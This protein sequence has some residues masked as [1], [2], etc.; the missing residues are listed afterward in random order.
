MVLWV[1]LRVYNQLEKLEDGMCLNCVFLISELFGK[2]E[3]CGVICEV[4]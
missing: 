4:D 3:R 1:F 2:I